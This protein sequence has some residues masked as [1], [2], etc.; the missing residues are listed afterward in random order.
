MPEDIMIQIPPNKENIGAVI[1][2]YNPDNSFQKRIEKILGQVKQIVIVDNC[3]FK[4][5]SLMIFSLMTNN[6]IFVIQ[7]ESNF[8]IAEALN[9]GL[10]WLKKR[11]F[12]W[13]LCLD[14][15]SSVFDGMIDT[16]I[17]VFDLYKNKSKLAVIGSNY[18]NSEGKPRYRCT[19]ERQY[20]EKKTVITSGSLISLTAFEAI[21][22]FRSDFFM[23]H[24]DHEFCLRAIERGFKV[25]LA[26]KPLMEHNI[27]Q[28]RL[29]HI[30]WKTIQ[31][32]VHSPD[33]YYYKARNH[34]LMLR[35]YFFK[36]IFWALKSIYAALNL[37]F[38]TCLFEDDRI[39]K[40]K[41]TL[42]GYWEGTFGNFDKINR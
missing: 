16:L 22:S 1:V 11:G 38:L 27:G 19:S 34:A 33:R 13:A 39:L 41:M 17:R 15:D 9:E 37:V 20:A 35:E 36:D 32:E 21:G 4:P 30:L 5:V 24:V 10:D 18:I 31:I 26:C 8:G 40:L 3:S 14:Q 25:I 29:C 42:K 6:N 23:D 28:N 12:Y 2:T 7:N